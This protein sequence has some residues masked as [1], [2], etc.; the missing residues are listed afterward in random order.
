MKMDQTFCLFKLCIF[1]TN[2]T[3]ELIVGE[4]KR[5]QS[6]I[7]CSKLPEVSFSVFVRSKAIGDINKFQA[8]SSIF[9]S[10]QYR[11]T[12]EPLLQHC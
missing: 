10:I 5:T 12:V 8:I 9:V 2:Q 7:K 6:K 1:I 11:T 4:C 3:I